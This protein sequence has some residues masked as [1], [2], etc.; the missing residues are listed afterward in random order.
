[1]KPRNKY[2]KRVAEL[3]ATLSEDIAIN[4]VEWYKKVSKGWDFGAG[5]FCY[6]TLSTNIAEF[7]VTRLYRGY[8][9]TDKSTDHFF[10]VEI[11][12]EFN[13]FGKKMYFGKSRT[14]GGYYD[15]FSFA[16]DIELKG[17]YK[18]YAGYTL[19]DL[20]DLSC[21]SHSQSDGERIACEKQNPKEI[22]RVICDNPVAETLYK[23]K[24]PMFGHLMW[25]THIKETCRAYTLAKRHGYVF[26]EETIPLWLDMVYAIIKC[27]KDWHNPVYIA[28]KDLFATH[29]QFVDMWNRKQRK[30]REKRERDAEAI[31]IKREYEENR[32]QLEQD[33][34]INEAY[35]KRRRKFYDMVL[36]D[37]LIECR[38]LRDCK[39]FEEEGTAMQHCVFRCRYYTK[40]YSLIMS[41]KIDGHRIETIEVD[42]SSFTIK[43][44]FGKHDH[45]T[46]HHQRILDL[47]NSQ[48]DTIK[49]YNKKRTSRRKK[50]A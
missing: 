47:V 30:V 12:R 18:N 11:L 24:D 15:S 27:K 17:I 35:I 2:E 29:D 46:L 3:N 37:G 13:D 21:A 42:L 16:S 48:M 32:K 45:F 39:E 9:F 25:R 28:P 38:V 43:Q 31:R 10:F 19:V 40:P 20:F 23:Q 1:M 34:S 41:A 14:M 33:K 8:K 50:A 5:C 44:C 26:C 6:F 49:E 36:T 22:A 7:E 4:D